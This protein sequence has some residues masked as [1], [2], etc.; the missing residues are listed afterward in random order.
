MEFAHLYFGDSP[1]AQAPT[2]T[3]KIKTK[4]GNDI[5]VFKASGDTPK[6][7]L[8][9]SLAAFAAKSYGLDKSAGQLG[10]FDED[11]VSAALSFASAKHV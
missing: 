5:R 1:A 3:L 10:C 6:G 11:N 4:Y 9:S 7:Q 8:F 2:P